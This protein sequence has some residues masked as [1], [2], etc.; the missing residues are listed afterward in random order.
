VARFAEKV[1]GYLALAAYLARPEADIAAV[2]RPGWRPVKPRR[3]MQHRVVW[4]VGYSG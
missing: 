4:A 2:G 1:D 3:P